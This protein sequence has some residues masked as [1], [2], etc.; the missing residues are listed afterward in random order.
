MTSDSARVRRNFCP[1]GVT[2]ESITAEGGFGVWGGRWAALGR[3]TESD[4]IVVPTTAFDRLARSSF[5]RQTAIDLIHFGIF[6]AR[7]EGGLH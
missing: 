3:L 1:S 4:A 7:L 6:M 2:P 5:E